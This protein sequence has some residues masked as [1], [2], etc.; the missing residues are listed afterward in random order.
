MKKKKRKTIEKGLGEEEDG[1]KGWC[2]QN[3]WRTLPW[4][5]A[6]ILIF[7]EKERRQWRNIGGKGKGEVARSRGGSTEQEQELQRLF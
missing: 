5:A 2:V 7:K 6:E 1:G 4:R 3:E